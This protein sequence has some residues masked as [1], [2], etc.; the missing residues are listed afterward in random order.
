MQLGDVIRSYC[1][2]CQETVTVHAIEMTEVEFWEAIRTDDDIE[3][4]HMIDVDADHRWMLQSHEKENLRK[5]AHFL[6]K[7]G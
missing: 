6:R 1:Y 4:G 2:L 7:N 3:V 5:N